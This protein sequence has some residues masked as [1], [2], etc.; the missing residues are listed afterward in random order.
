LAIATPLH[1]RA[2]L[3]E[4]VRQLIEPLPAR[5]AHR[6]EAGATASAFS[7]RHELRV[8]GDVAHQSRIDVELRHAGERVFHEL[9]E[10]EHRD[11]AVLLLHVG[12]RRVVAIG[13]RLRRRCGACASPGACGRAPTRAPRASGRRP[14]PEQAADRPGASGHAIEARLVGGRLRLRALARRH[15]HGRGRDTGTGSFQ[16]VASVHARHSVGV[17]GG[18]Q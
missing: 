4:R 17:D 1:L 16:K 9:R 18:R 12:G 7:G 14:V 2:G 13:G 5:R 15:H 11:L 8:V 3:D 10:V 6:I